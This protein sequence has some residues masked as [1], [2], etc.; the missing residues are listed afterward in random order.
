MDKILKGVCFLSQAE[1]SQ[2][3]P[4]KREWFI[5]DAFIGFLIIVSSGKICE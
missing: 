4:E 2:W 5:L 1:N 3:V